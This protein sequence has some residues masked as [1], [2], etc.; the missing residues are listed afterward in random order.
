MTVVDLGDLER[1]LLKAQLDCEA[2]LTAGASEKFLE[3]TS[4]IAA[5]E[6]QIEQHLAQ[7]PPEPPPAE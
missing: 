6:R 4:R 7:H 1:R 5:L 2:W 3:A